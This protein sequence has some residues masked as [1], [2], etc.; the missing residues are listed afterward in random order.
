MLMPRTGLRVDRELKPHLWMLAAIAAGTALLAAWPQWVIHAGYRCEL[1][2]LMGLRCP[3]CGMT[4]D[5]AA[6]LHGR[7]PALNP[8][9]WVAAAAV[10]GVYPAAVL[11]GWQRKRLDVFYSRAVRSG[12]VVALAVMLVLNNVR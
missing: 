12:V 8:C 7:R 10:Y 4:R 1:Q 2:M 11:V 3:F 5:F 6:M 9:S